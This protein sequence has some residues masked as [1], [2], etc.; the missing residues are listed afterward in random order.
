MMFFYRVALVLL[1]CFSSHVAYGSEEDLTAEQWLKRMSEAVKMQ[2]YQGRSIFHN[3]HQ[4]TSVRVMHAFVNG[5]SWDRIVHLSGEPAEI[6]RKGQQIACLHPQ[7]AI[8]LQGVTS[9]GALVEPFNS[10]DFSASSLYRFRKTGKG[11]VAGRAAQIIN[12]IPEDKARYG[13]QLAIDKSTGVLLKTVML[14]H[15][16]DALEV[17]EFV[18]IDI[19]SPLSAELFEPGEGVKWIQNTPLNVSSEDSKLQNWDVNWLPK[20]FNL[21][22]QGVRNFGGEHVNAR[23]YTDGLAVFTVF[24]EKSY[25]AHY[26]EGRKQRGATIAL[27]RHLNHE[28][29]GFLVTVVGE[30]PLET[31]MQVAA[32]VQQN[33]SDSANHD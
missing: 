21:A 12:V 20:G 6:V 29:Q 10:I 5:E 25:G 13:Y 3:G 22:K 26:I 32:S 17:F 9:R 23:V 31:A 27:S 2:T 33:N 7:S 14:N 4:M 24:L 11:R 28:G 19:G 1:V 15:K 16:G 8:Q 18:D 30:V